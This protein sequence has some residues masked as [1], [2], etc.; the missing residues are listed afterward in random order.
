[1]RFAELIRLPLVCLFLPSL[2]LT[3][4]ELRVDI[5]RD[6]KN[7]AAQT[8]PGYV[9]WA[10]ADAVGTLSKGIAA[11]TRTFQVPATNETVSV[12]LAM[13]PASRGAGGTGLTYTYHAASSLAEGGKLTADGITVE[14]SIANAGGQIEMTITGLAAGKHS[15][16]TFHNAGDSAL[17]LGALAPIKAHLNGAHVATVTPSIRANDGATPTVYFSFSTSSPNDVTTILFEADA[18]SSAATKNVVLNGFEIDTSNAAR[19]AHSPSP[20]H[21]DTQAKAAADGVRLSWSAAKLGAVDS[22]DLYFGT[23]ADAVRTATR[24]SS[25]YLGNQSESSRSVPVTDQSA[26]YHWRVDERDEL[27]NVTVGDVWSFSLGAPEGVAQAIFVCLSGKAGP[28]STVV[29]PAPGFGWNYS[30]AAP[31][32]GDSWNRIPRPAAV[33]VTDPSLAPAGGAT[34]KK[35]GIHTLDT[36]DNVALVDAT[37]KP[38]N[39]KLTVRLEIATLATDKARSE[40]SIHSKSKGALPA[41]LMDVSWRVFLPQNTLHFSVTGLVP[42]QAY[43][44]YGYAAALDPAKNLEGANDGAFFTLTAANRV[45]GSKGTAETQGGYCASVLTYNPESGKITPSPVGT[46]WIK[47]PAI[48]DANGQV[49]FSTTRNSFGRHFVNGFQL[50]P[51][52]KP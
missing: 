35:S 9:Q 24:S 25:V 39:A 20:A 33:D 45:A 2:A 16:L 19:R 52:S 5:N 48:A 10:P 38:T 51:S 40:P 43:D 13:T 34:A 11:I 26:T 47:L 14:P 23:D 28:K 32:G 1:M 12:S 36:A 22:H 30:A 8:A 17:Q 50:V 18:S 3:A 27:G 29:I 42:G 46:T 44:L 21:L 7:T 41:G 37:G 4:G 31:T 6:G 49:N 15:L